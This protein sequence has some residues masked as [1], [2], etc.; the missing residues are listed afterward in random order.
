MQASARRCLAVVLAAGEGTRMRSSKPKVLHEVA[1]L[2]M[3]A[4]VLNAVA[5][6]GADGVA[7]VVGPGREVIVVVRTDD[8]GTAGRYEQRPEPD[9][10][11]ARAAL[12]NLRKAIRATR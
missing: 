5:E 1:G 3:L 10:D 4:H 8:S 7:I 11:E 12:E 6:A 2:S 9:P